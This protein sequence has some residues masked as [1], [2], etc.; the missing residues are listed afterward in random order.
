[1]KN[2]IITAV[3]LVADIFAAF[4]GYTHAYDPSDHLVWWSAALGFVCTNTALV[5]F[6]VLIINM[7]KVSGT[8]K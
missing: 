5:L 2:L 8:F 1:M 7:H 3:A 6:F 4:F